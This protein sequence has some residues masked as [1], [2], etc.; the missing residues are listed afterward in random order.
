MRFKDLNEIDYL[1]YKA[2]F[3]LNVNRGVEYID[4][5][6]CDLKTRNVSFDVAFEIILRYIESNTLVIGND[7]IEALFDSLYKYYEKSD[8]DDR[9]YIDLLECYINGDIENYEV[10][11]IY[12]DDFINR[13][14]LSFNMLFAPYYLNVLVERTEDIEEINRINE[15]VK[16]FIVEFKNRNGRL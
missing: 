15:K 2:D 4:Q 8:T 1:T 5:A 10:D 13:A 7:V 3:I 6:M 9:I 14:P 11:N 16:N 12:T